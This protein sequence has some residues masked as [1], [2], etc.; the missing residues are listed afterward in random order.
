[1]TDAFPVGTTHSAFPPVH[2][3]P[4]TTWCEPIHGGYIRWQYDGSAWVY[5]S[6]TIRT[7]EEGAT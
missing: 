4:G 5:V 1:M 6:D 3:D 7:H 2:P